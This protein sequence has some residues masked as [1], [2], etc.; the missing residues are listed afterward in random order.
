MCRNLLQEFSCKDE[1]RSGMVAGDEYVVRESVCLC[2]YTYTAMEMI[3][4]RSK[5]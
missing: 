2:L 4:K 3:Q 5:R 1:Q